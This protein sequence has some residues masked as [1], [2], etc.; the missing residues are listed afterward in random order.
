[1]K[2]SSLIWKNLMSGRNLIKEVSRSTIGP[3]HSINIAEVLWLAS[4][5]KATLLPN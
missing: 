5:S 4:G 3:G 2:G 1:M